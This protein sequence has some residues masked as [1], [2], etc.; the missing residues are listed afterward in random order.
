VW[1]GSKR[2]QASRVVTDVTGRLFSHFSS[3][4]AS[5]FSPGSLAP[6]RQTA[7]DGL[8]VTIASLRQLLRPV[9]RYTTMV[10]EGSAIASGFRPQ[11]KLGGYEFY[12]E[13]LKSPK[14]IVAPMVDQ[15]ELVSV[16][17]FNFLRSSLL[18]GVARSLPEVW[19][20]STFIHYLHPSTE[21]SSCIC[22]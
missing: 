4:S 13:V 2:D 1:L 19:R 8:R 3:A 9:V 16:Y 11:R 22:S 7:G 12:R 18:A 21:G 14:F 17:L 20:G 5:C 6:S 15:S 10:E